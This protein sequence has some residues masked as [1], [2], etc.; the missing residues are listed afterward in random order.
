V[1]QRVLS[2][3]VAGTREASDVDDPSTKSDVDTGAA[4]GSEADEGMRSARGGPSA[5][6][7]RSESRPLK[8]CRDGP[9]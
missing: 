6:G 9:A 7:I 3:V 5:I 1:L 8:C 2:V 4:G